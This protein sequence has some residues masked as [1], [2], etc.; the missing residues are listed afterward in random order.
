MSKDCSDLRKYVEEIINNNKDLLD[1]L[2]S[3]AEEKGI[4]V[5]EAPFAKYMALI[6]FSQRLDELVNKEIKDLADNFKV[7]ELVKRFSE[8]KNLA[9][10]LNSF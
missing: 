7:L 2:D 9:N 10:E 8:R 1:F 6:S 4:K 5:N 3:V